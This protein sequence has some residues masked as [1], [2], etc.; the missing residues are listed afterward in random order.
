MKEYN[1]QTGK[2]GEEIAGEFL[3]KKGYKILEQNARSKFG[4][5]DLVAR[6]G[7]ELVVVEVRTKRGEF[8]GTPEESLNKKKL[9]KLWMNAWAYTSRIHWK[10]GCRIDAVCVVLRQ[11]NT[12]ERIQHYENI[13]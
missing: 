1:L 9:K 7:K 10:G 4:E 12:I 6:D 13:C 11:D 2:I 3:K 5:I 8:F